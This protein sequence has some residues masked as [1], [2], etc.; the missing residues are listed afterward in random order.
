MDKNELIINHLYLAKSLTKS[1][2]C[3]FKMICYDELEEIA[4][5]GLVDAAHR[6]K[7]SMGVLFKTYAHRRI[8]GHLN[9]YIRLTI[10]DRIRFV[11][12]DENKFT[13]TQVFNSEDFFSKISSLVSSKD[14]E[15]IKLRYVDGF[16]SDE[17]GE[18]LGVSK[19]SIEVQLSRCKKAL[20]KMVD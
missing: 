12:L 15:L 9:D 14:K 6:Y 11:A 13:Y 10:K 4:Y 3:F 5:E 8:S 7:P 1:K 2:S 19:N 17:I 20:K 18:K 16:T